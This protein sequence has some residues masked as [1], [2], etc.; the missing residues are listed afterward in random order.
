MDKTVS[1]LKDGLKKYWNYNDFRYPQQ[2]IMEAILA[3][4]DCLVVL[5]TG[6]GKS[7][8]FQ[9]PALLQTGLTIVIS[10]LVA[11]MENQVQ[12]LRQKNLPATLL[13][14]EVRHSSIRF[15]P[16]FF[17]SSILN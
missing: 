10:P 11:L 6:G 5:P 15:A 17:K 14:G 8:C 3:G 12:Q 16:F 7:L 2:E 13:H 4:K 1:L 9:L